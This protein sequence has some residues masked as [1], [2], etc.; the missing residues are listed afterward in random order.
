MLLN[1]KMKNNNNTKNT[2]IQ[3]TYAD[4][5]TYPQKKGQ[6]KNFESFV[7]YCKTN[8]YCEII[9]EFCCLK[10]KVSGQISALRTFC[11]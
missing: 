9:T 6:N 4:V 2:H 5:Q 8:V 3:Y 7:C 10:A 1:F 11:A